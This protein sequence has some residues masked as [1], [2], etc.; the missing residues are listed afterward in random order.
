MKRSSRKGSGLVHGSI[1][2]SYST[3]SLLAVF[4]VPLTDAHVGSRCAEASIDMV[5][6]VKP[7]HGGIGKES[8]LS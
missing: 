3:V 7:H 5:A 8:K 6:N 4:M 1:S 2:Q